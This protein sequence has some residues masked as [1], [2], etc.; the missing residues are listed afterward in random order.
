MR[1]ALAVFAVFTAFSVFAEDKYF[2]L[3][4]DFKN[5]PN[6]PIT[7]LQGVITTENETT[8]VCL[9]DGLIR[10]HK[11][12]SVHLSGKRWLSGNEVFGLLLG[13][14]DTSVW[15][16]TN[17]GWS[18]ISEME[19][20]LSR[21][22]ELLQRNFESRPRRHG[23]V[24]NVQLKAP[25][26]FDGAWQEVSGND[27]LWT[28]LYAAAQSFRYAETGSKEAR[29]Q[30]VR[31]MKAL[32]RLESITGISGFPA[33]A[34]I[35]ESEPQFNQRLVDSSPEWHRSTV[36]PG[37]WWKGDT[38]SD[39]IAGHF[40]AYYVFYELAANDE[41]KA[42]V[43]ATCKR[44][45]DHIL[46]N[47]YCLVD[48]DGEPTLWGV[49]APEK[50][51]DD[52]KWKEEHALG[53]L[54]ILS[55]LKVA[56]WITGDVRYKRAYQSLISNHHYAQNTL[57]A[58]TVVPEIV[59]H[60]WQLLFISFYPLLRLE[61]DDNL[62]A[63]Y[64]EAL[65]RVWEK[66]CAQESPL[67]NFIYGACSGKPCDQKEARKALKEMPLDFVNWEVKNSHRPDLKNKSLEKPLSWIERPLHRWDKSP[68]VLDGGNGMQEID[69][70]IFL[71]PYWL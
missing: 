63:T 50:I 14:D 57:E 18:Q 67:W 27:G 66:T 58:I 69:Q 20:T 16:K 15:V 36:E 54:E 39:E 55:H 21:K 60:D 4:R 37:W 23:Y 30:A 44:V 51:N 48:V 24:S 34:I 71:L 7:D 70:T 62:R 26:V 43:R 29:D 45:M 22:S 38:S 5:S 33:R 40:F 31:S 56:V 17:N 68:F 65:D 11:G 53:S 12:E 59:S 41:E 46:D 10:I 64:L 28:A 47:G 3:T 9:D 13:G 1:A 19:T 32:L 6:V 8:W 42:L 52:P 2:Q 25:G 61:T 35:H 49:W